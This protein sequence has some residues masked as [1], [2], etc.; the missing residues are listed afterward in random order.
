MH[1]GRWVLTY[2]WT[3]VANTITATESI[4]SGGRFTA[5]V[6]FEVACDGSVKLADKQHD[7]TFRLQLSFKLPSPQDAQGESAAIAEALVSM[8]YA[9]A[10]LKMNGAFPVIEATATFKPGPVTLSQGTDKAVLGALT[11]AFKMNAATRKLVWVFTRTEAPER[12]QWLSAQHVATPAQL[13]SG[14]DAAAGLSSA[15]VIDPSLVDLDWRNHTLGAKSLPKG[16]SKGVSFGATM[17]PIGQKPNLQVVTAKIEEVFL[18]HQAAVTD[19]YTLH[20]AD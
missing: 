1:A 16:V 13:F 20:V 9:D 12:P 7:G 18:S 17:V 2:D 19:T 6:D 3:T 4:H 11:G 8:T 5:D 15:F 10:K 14:D